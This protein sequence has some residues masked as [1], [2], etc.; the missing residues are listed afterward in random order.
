MNKWGLEQNDI[1]WRYFLAIEDDLI[2]LARY[3][4]LAESNYQTHSIECTR[5][6]LASCSEA[7]V[8]LKLA[9]GLGRNRG[10]KDCFSALGERSKILASSEITI[11]RGG[12]VLRPWVDWTSTT[13]PF[14]WDAHNAVKHARSE[15]VGKANLKN[16]LDA[17]AG[18]FAALLIYLPGVGARAVMPAPLLLRADQ[19]L[20]S[21]DMSP[22][23]AMVSFGDP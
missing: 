22:E 19:Q 15:N 5:L 23:G 6:L 9:S 12:L 10:M 14:W 4:D 2:R 16:M 21:H 11:P 18:L 1:H 8:V 7:E 3:I 17:V 13:L 20:G